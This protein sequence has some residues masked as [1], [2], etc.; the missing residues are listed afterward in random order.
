M[1]RMR[2]AGVRHILLVED[3]SEIR[4]TMRIA[5][6][7]ADDYR[8]AS[9][10]GLDEAEAA[11]EDERPDLLIL[12][13]VVPR[14][15]GF[16]GRSGMEFAAF[17]LA[18]EVPMIL[19][20]GHADLADKLEELRFPLLRKPFAIDALQGAV[21]AALRR[22]EDNLRHV[23]EALDYLLHHRDEFAALLEWLG[24]L[25]DAI[26]GAAPRPKRK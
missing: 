18:R 15:R 12:D 2:E 22:P 14:T 6:E 16:P 7:E 11:L 19:M 13:A 26:P 20:T 3:E 25:G 9:A 4:R 10:G 1:S 23:R 5:L 21:E 24:R 8:V 17:A